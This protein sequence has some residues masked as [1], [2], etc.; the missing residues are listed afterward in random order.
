MLLLIESGLVLIAVLVAFVCPEVGSHWF[1]KLERSFARLARRRGLAVVSVGL[2]AL[3]L[4]ASLLP[5]LPIPEPLV[6]DE[7]GYLLAADTFAHGRVTNP[8]HPM[9]IHFETFSVIQKPTYQSYA[10]PAQGLILALG[11]VITGHP[12]WGVWLSVGLMCA[13][14][15]WML[16]GWLAPEWALLGGLLAILRYGIFG[17]WANSYWGGA[18][19]AIGGA[20]VLGALPRIIRSQRVRDALLL[21]LGLAILANSRPYEGVVLSLPVAVALLVWMMSQQHPPFKVSLRR[22]V[23][24]LCLLLIVIASG[25]GYYCWRITG[26]PLRMPYQVERETYAV[27]P[28]FFWQSTRAQPTYPYEAMRKAYADGEPKLYMILRT[29]VWF[30]YVTLKKAVGFW[31]FY[32]GPVLT[33]PLFMLLVV[34]PYG[35]SLRQISR[36]SR[37]LLL[38]FGVSLV[39]LTLGM[40]FDPHYA[41][42]ISG[43]TL[44]ILLLATRRLRLWR[45]SKGRTGLLMSRLI[46]VICLI[47]FLLRATAGPLHIPLAH[48]E[49]SPWSAWYQL[50]PQSFGRA[51]IMKQ[52]QEAAGRHLV[53]VRYKD[54]HNPFNEWVYNE[55]D[56]DASKIVWARETTPTENGDLVKYFEGRHVWLLEPDETPQR[57]SRYA[58]SAGELNPVSQQ[59]NNRQ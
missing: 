33:L 2:L 19:G 8:T 30:I 1:E 46:P 51:A 32:I 42:P 55:A 52:L 15:C 4:R 50:G 47:M 37:S 21:G 48:P 5:I 53:V 59:M 36:D 7:F 35:F 38:I 3:A 56:I 6:H 10:Q 16:Q 44:A 54:S 28:Y 27:A 45:S 13:A 20:L 40:F 12:F 41:A 57:I 22:V 34:L 18:A 26:N 43:L 9:W 39:G 31:C 23:A 24:P 25:I 58:L 11:K 17:Y 14:I 49:W 29:P